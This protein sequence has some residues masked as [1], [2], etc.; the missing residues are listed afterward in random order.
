M[1]K[2]GW[3]A[4]VTWEEGNVFLGSDDAGHTVVY[5]SAEGVQR[6]IGPMR[7]LL[8][9]LGACT[10]MDIV[11]ILN[12]RKQKLLSLKIQLSGERPEH[13]LPKPWTSIHVKYLLSGVD[14]DIKYV[15]EAITDSTEKFCSVGAT[16]QPTAKI[17]HSYEIV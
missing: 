7:A 9:S 5:D 8:T 2:E 12:K 4:E 1:S 3:Q 11:A 17:T 15:E 10:G 16:L 6:G 13:G 14:L